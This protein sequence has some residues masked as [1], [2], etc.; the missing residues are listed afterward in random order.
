MSVLTTKQTG[1]AG[2]VRIYVSCLRRTALPY[3]DN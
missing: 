3:L 2:Y 1:V